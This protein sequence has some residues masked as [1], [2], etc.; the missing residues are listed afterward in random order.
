MTAYKEFSYYYDSLM[1]PDFY[2]DYLEFIHKHANLKTVL[3]LGCGTGL[4]AIELAKEGH[5]VLATDLSEDMVNITAL[6]AKDEGV[7]LLTETIDMC[8][9]ALSQPVDTILCLTDAINYVLSKKKVQD[10]FNNVY[11]GLKYNGTF[12]FDVNSLY[13]CNVI[14]D[15]Y[16]EKNEDEDFFFSWDVESDHK[17][18]ITHHII[19]DED[20]HHVDETHRQKTLPVEEYV[21]MLRKAGFKSIAYYSDFGEYKEECE[22]I[23]FVVKKVRD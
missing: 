5:Q 2:S 10:V 9:F 17:G 15:D 3:E 1:D 12:I 20:G 6:K 4:T 14:L 18:G 19:I 8:D 16:H 11:E 23:I 7:E 21:K 22:R 13:K